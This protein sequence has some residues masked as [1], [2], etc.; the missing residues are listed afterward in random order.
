MDILHTHKSEVS[1]EKVKRNPQQT[2][3]EGRNLRELKSRVTTGSW[4]APV[5]ASKTVAPWNLVVDG[6]R[7]RGV[8]GTR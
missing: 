7:L 5:L 4:W 6:W 8:S 1:Q 3:N 2:A